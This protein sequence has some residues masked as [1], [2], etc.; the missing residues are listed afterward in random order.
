LAEG[1]AALEEARGHLSAAA[2]PKSLTLCLTNLAIARTVAGEFEVARALLDESLAV[3]AHSKAD[4]WVWR[5]RIYKAEVEFAEGQLDE[6]IRQAR[7]VV[8]LSRAARRT[9]LLGHALCNLAGYLI[10][11][12]DLEEAGAALREGLPLAQESELDAVAG[13][14]A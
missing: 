1:L 14:I 12:G 13:E 3:G 6:A 9:G 8:S 10:A 7:E 4:F 5:A 11:R 2:H